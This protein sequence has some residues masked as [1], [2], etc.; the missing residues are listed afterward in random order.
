MGKLKPK[1]EITPEIQHVIQW[2]AEY[3][4]A[5]EVQVKSCSDDGVA[6]STNWRVD[7][8]IKFESDGKTQSGIR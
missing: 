2:L 6:V 5:T 8:P 3:S 4:V 7:L 1:R